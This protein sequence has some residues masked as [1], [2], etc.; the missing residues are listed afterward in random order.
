MEANHLI[1][2]K[3]PELIQ[4]VRLIRAK[5]DDYMQ[6]L[7]NDELAW[8]GPDHC[9]TLPPS[10]APCERGTS[11]DW[12]L[13]HDMASYFQGQHQARIKVRVAVAGCGEGYAFIQFRLKSLSDYPACHEW[14]RMEREYVC[15]NA[16]VDFSID[17]DRMDHV[18]DSLT[19]SGQSFTY[20][21][22]RHDE[23]GALIVDTGDIGIDVTQGGEC[24][25]ACK[26]AVMTENTQADGY[27]VAPDYERNPVTRMFIY[28]TCRRGVCP[29]EP[30]ETVVRECQCLNEFSS[31]VAAV[32]T[33]RQAGMD[34]ICSDG[35]RK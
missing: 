1:D 24:V 25:Q 4:S 20:Q 30:G 17:T 5:W 18:A 19:P 3:M 29:T 22:Q 21:D 35:I 6:I 26:L 14:W 11:W 32:E 13:N 23:S 15:K 10:G 12:A 8:C 7:I 31:T 2:I 34:M 28:R 9:E 27:H 16:P 33:L